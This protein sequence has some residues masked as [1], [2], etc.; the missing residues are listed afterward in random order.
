MSSSSSEDRFVPTPEEVEAG[1]LRRRARGKEEREAPPRPRKGLRRFIRGKGVG[2][3]R[4]FIDP[5]SED[6]PA[7]SDSA[8]ETKSGDVSPESGKRPDVAEG[9]A[10][11]ELEEVDG[12][13]QKDGDTP[14]SK[15]RRIR[16]VTV[17]PSRPPAP[18]E[19]DLPVEQR[20]FYAKT[21]RK[22]H[23]MGPLTGG[24]AKCMKCG[25]EG[26]IVIQAY[27]NWP[28]SVTNYHL[29]GRALRV[30]CKGATD[31]E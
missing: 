9:F 10:S 18:P 15:R 31:S 4:R 21:A 27:D 16:K 13:E 30:T 2:A 11:P 29:L 6:S 1:Q 28:G 14:A 17:R 24:S 22:G 8:E 7:V 23:D 5:D 25:E 3:R 20:D 26:H 19:E 12:P